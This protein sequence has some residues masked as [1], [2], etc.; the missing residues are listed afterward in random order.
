MN[1]VG[2]TQRNDTQALLSCGFG[3]LP[4][5]MVGRQLLLRAADW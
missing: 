5:L 4:E 3:V 1:S 2:W